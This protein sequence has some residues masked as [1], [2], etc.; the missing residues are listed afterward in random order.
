MFAL[1][2][3]VERFSQWSYCGYCRGSG[4]IIVNNQKIDHSAWR[5]LAFINVPTHNHKLKNKKADKDFLGL[6]Y[7]I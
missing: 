6:F 1:Y 5:L 3:I 4:Y 7:G 2:Y